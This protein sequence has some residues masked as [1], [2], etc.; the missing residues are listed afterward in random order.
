MALFQNVTLMKNHNL[1]SIVDVVTGAAPMG[2]ETLQKLHRLFPK[3]NILQ[4]YGKFGLDTPSPPATL[5]VYGV[6]R[7]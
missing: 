7:N 3:W 1:S 2:P 4:G 6:L 5:S